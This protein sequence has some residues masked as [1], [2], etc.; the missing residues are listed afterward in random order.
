MRVSIVV[1]VLLLTAT[2]HGDRGVVVTL[3]GGAMFDRYDADHLG[4]S[5]QER[6]WGAGFEL[7]VAYRFFDQ[8]AVG[9]H[10]AAARSER[11]TR[12]VDAPV[13][14]PD[15]V[16]A[17]IPALL[18]VTAEYTIAD[19]VWLAP[20][21]GVLDLETRYDHDEGQCDS[22]YGYHDQTIERRLAY[23]IG[24]GVDVLNIGDHRIGAFVQ[25]DRARHTSPP[26]M[27]SA[28]AGFYPDDFDDDLLVTFGVAYRYW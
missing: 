22:F 11:R 12:C 16:F 19:R 10:F 18:G 4:T 25:V 26:L 15:H 17:I 23:G 24:L 9:V 27:G 13:S 6:R 8:L 7:D 20:W 3:G 5:F 14:R 21:L 2:A 1:G 28:S